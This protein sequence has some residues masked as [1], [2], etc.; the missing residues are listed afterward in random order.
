MFANWLPV[1]TCIL[2]AVLTIEGLL[3]L[4]AIDIMDRDLPYAG[5]RYSCGTDIQSPCHVR[6]DVHVLN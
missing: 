2:L 3:V 5:E 4:R 1:V 6:G